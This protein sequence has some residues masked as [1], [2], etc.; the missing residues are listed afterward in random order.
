MEQVFERT[1]GSALFA[2]WI[3]GV[4]T[5]LAGGLL[6]CVQHDMR[7][8]SSQSLRKCKADALR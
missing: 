3:L 8:R 2:V 4:L 7:A 1:Q 6:A 5:A